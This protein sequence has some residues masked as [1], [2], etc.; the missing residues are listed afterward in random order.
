M[1][2]RHTMIAQILAVLAALLPTSFV[3]GA[4]DAGPMYDGQIKAGEK[5][6]VD[7]LIGVLLDARENNRLPTATFTFF[8]TPPPVSDGLLTVVA[9]GDLG[10]G[11]DDAG[12]V[13]EE[14]F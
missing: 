14:D 6:D 2:T 11:L 9:A 7:G 1:D 12:T 4:A 5:G 8:D 10:I 3:P 13:V